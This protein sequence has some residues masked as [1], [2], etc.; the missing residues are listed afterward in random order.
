MAD[1]STSTK[2][3]RSSEVVSR[4]AGRSSSEFAPSRLP[5]V[6]AAQPQQ[7]AGAEARGDPM[8]LAGGNGARWRDD[9]DGSAV[10]HQRL[11]PVTRP[12]E[13]V[14]V[15]VGIV[16]PRLITVHAWLAP[17]QEGAGER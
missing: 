7:R 15:P 13:R 6:R 3:V 9:S 4:N 12:V 2:K 8:P 1:R 11:Q 16:R 14:V 10:W 17:E 5:P